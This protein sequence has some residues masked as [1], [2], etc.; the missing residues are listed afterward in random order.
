MAKKDKKEKKQK[1]GKEKPE[2][3]RKKRN[4]ED[5]NP[6][7][8]YPGSDKTKSRQARLLI[9][10]CAIAFGL[11]IYTIHFF[12]Y[13]TVRQQEAAAAAAAAAAASAPVEPIGENW[14]L[15][16]D[17]TYA[18]MDNPP[19]LPQT[20]DQPAL[21]GAEASGEDETGE[22]SGQEPAEGEESEEESTAE[23][24]PPSENT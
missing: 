16:P 13:I 9:V 2:K 4:E 17:G 8:P 3:K 1:K 6:N 23:A 24:E 11:M 10:L 20:S 7:I 18:T 12:R 15:R 19:S 14:Y 22:P 5:E 21:P